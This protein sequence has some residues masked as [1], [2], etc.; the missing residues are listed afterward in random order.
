MTGGLHLDGW[1][2][3]SDAYFSYQDQKRR[4][5]ILDDSRVGAFGA[6]SLFVLILLKVG[7][8]YEIIYQGNSIFMLFL[9]V[10]PFL[11]RIALLLFFLTSPNGKEEGLAVYFKSKVNVKKIWIALIFYTV[12][13]CTLTFYLFNNVAF[14]IFISMVLFVFIYRKWTMKNFGGMTGI[15]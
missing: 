2:D 10:I 13:F 7:F 12:L 1:I 3:M 8:I 15:Y 9:F 5:A 11:S 4:L 14:L 6:I